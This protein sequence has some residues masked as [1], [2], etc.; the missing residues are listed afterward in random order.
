MALWLYFSSLQ[1]IPLASAVA[2]QYTSPVFTAVFAGLLL[3]ERMGKW[4]WVF[5]LVSMI[6]VG[7]IKG[8]DSRIPMEYVAIG[9]A[10]ALF[11]GLAYTSIR[12]LHTTE[13]PYVIIIYFPMLALPI[14]AIYS[15]LNWI[16][17]IG[18]DWL[19]ILAMGILT[20]FGQISATKAIHL[21]RL[22]NVTFLNYFGIIL[23]LG[24]GYVLFQETF[25]WVS[26][27]GMGMVLAGIF[28][29]LVDK[30]KIKAKKSSFISSIWH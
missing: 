6:G 1:K 24:L 3:K 10:S 22:E 20:Q 12:K 13:N 15:W 21:E 5:F 19:F 29:N 17:P 8:Y 9:L 14:T 11:S 27:T 30:E 16:Q 7:F 25:D 28:L 18:V 2:I 26:I 4:K 23:A